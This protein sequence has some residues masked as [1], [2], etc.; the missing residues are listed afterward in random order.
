MIPVT[1]QGRAEAERARL[2]ALK[3]SAYSDSQEGPSRPV[4]PGEI[5]AGD[6]HRPL[7][8]EGHGADS[9][10]NAGGPR[11]VDLTGSQAMGVLIPAHVQASM[12]PAGGDR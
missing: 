12:G 6:F 2:A 1:Q 9:P 10:Q 8:T 7:I 11:H 4:A 5:E 3:G